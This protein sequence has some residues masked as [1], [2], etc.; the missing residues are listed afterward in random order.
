MHKTKLG[1]DHSSTIISIAY[2]ANTYKKQGRWKDVEEL[3]VQVLEINK[4]KLGVDHPDT[5]SSMA[6]L[7]IGIKADGIMQNSCVS[8]LEIERGN[9]Q[10]R[11]QE[12]VWH[13]RPELAPLSEL[14]SKSSARGT[15]SEERG[16]ESD[17]WL[18]LSSP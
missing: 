15:E 11:P 7:S 17:Q 10:R 3:Q 6:N 4:K 2:L 8:L 12:K 9:S 16:G 1:A 13:S 5:L 18:G 14:F